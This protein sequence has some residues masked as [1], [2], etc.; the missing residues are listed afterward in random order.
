M[1]SATLPWFDLDNAAAYQRW[2]DWKCA[3]YPASFGALRVAVADPLALST[4]E[5]AALQDRLD[6]YNMAIYASR[7]DAAR[8]YPVAIGEAFGLRRVDTNLGA[9][10]D[11]VTEIE[12][13]DSALHQRYIPYS[14]KPLSWHVDGYYNPPARRIRGMMLHCVSPAAMGGVNALL[15]IEMAYIYLRDIA[16]DW[17]RVLSEPDCLTIP[18]NMVDGQEVRAAETGPV[19]S[20]D[21]RGYLH[22]RYSA[23]K[24]NIE[25]KTGTEEPVAALI[26]LMHGKRQAAINDWIFRGTLAAG[27]GLICNN[28]LH[29]RTAFEDDPAAPRLLYRLRY[30]DRAPTRVLL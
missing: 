5:R 11:G 22:M 26:E 25:W 15:D 24:R 6:R 14:S 9:A 2:R 16:P 1:G 27:E 13:K 17:I 29:N 28:V 19:F 21:E 3:Q 7:D 12:V 23:R 8:R 20:F 30:L 18:A 4:A 10:E